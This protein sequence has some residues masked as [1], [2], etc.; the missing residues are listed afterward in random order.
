MKNLKI[1][2]IVYAVGMLINFFMSIPTNIL[3][4]RTVYEM[5]SFFRF[6]DILSSLLILLT[7]LFL[8]VTFY[9]YLMQI[10]KEKEK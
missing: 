5:L 10:E 7:S 8:F 2:I 4:E 1:A 9:L 3:P 6:L